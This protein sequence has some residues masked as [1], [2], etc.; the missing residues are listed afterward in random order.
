MDVRHYVRMSQ[1]M[2]CQPMQPSSFTI[3]AILMIQPGFVCIFS[4]NLSQAVRGIMSTRA[5]RRI[6][7]VTI[8][9]SDLQISPVHSASL[10]E[11][12][13]HLIHQSTRKIAGSSPAGLGVF[14]EE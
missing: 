9:I 11:I 6:K 1:T 2:Y 7:Q 12:A 4:K 3:S 14:R 13:D 10:A 5:A 8:R